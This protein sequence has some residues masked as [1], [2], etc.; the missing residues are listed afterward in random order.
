MEKVCFFYLHRPQDRSLE[1]KVNIQ[2]AIAHPFVSIKIMVNKF[3]QI[4]HCH[5]LYV[6]L[7]LSH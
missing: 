2:V 4:Y 7:G 3:L 6:M 1:W 5:L